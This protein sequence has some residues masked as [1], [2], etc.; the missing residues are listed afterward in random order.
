MVKHWD[1]PQLKLETLNALGGGIAHEFNNLLGVVTG[2]T[3]VALEEL[4][5]REPKVAK[6]LQAVLEATRRAETLAN[7]ILAFSHHHSDGRLP[8]LV[9]P[10]LRAVL[11][12]VRCGLGDEVRLRSRLEAAQA[13][14][15]ADPYQLHHLLQ[16]LLGGV[17]ATVRPGGRFTVAL[18][19]VPAVGR[20]QT[21]SA[22]PLGRFLRLTVAAAGGIRPPEV[23]PA[24]LEGWDQRVDTATTLGALGGEASALKPWGSLWRIAAEHGG[25]YAFHEDAE[26]FA[27]VLY[28]PQARDTDAEGKDAVAVQ[29][30]GETVLWLDDEPPLVELGEEML[31][32][33]GYEPVGF[34]SS[35]AALE[36]FCA[37]PQRFDVVLTDERMPGLTGTQLA[38]RLRAL[39]PDLPV[40]LVTGYGGPLLDQRVQQ[41]G[42]CTV[43]TKPL[44]TKPL[45]TALKTALENCAAPLGA[46]VLDER[47]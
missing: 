10:L 23:P 28:L 27:L 42:V 32:A 9:Q 11:K 17:A 25:R 20:G 6:R 47:G 14:V 40:I 22:L 34:T 29:G 36:A 41:S 44:R 43:L 21:A 35:S 45:A 46:E 15:M 3:E 13:L 16:Q 4:G 1:D 7:Q 19:P 38:A 2:Y 39:R 24:L 33:L 5:A 8:L 18:E 37:D 31:A 26:G 12:G 30:R